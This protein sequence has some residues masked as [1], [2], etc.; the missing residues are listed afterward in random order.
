MHAAFYLAFAGFLQMGEFTYNRIESD[1]SSWNLTQ[2]SVSFS[3]DWLFFIIPSCKTDP[4]CQ[5]II[6]TIS[7]ASDKDCAVTSLTNLF[8][9]FP[10]ANHQLLFTNHAG[11]FNHSYVTKKLQKRVCML[12]YEGNYTGHSF[13]RGAATSAR[14]AGLSEDEIQLLGRWKSNCYC[15]YIKTHPN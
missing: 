11:T 7:V 14:L 1:F 3:K 6:L 10:K 4:F 12:G 2:G 8:T 15:L 5:G 13:R 9:Q